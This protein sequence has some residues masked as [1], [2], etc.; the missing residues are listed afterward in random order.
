MRWFFVPVGARYINRQ[1]LGI[2]FAALAILL[3]LRWAT[4]L[5]SFWKK[6]PPA[7]SRQIAYSILSYCACRN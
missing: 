3:S 7:T 2:F 1:V 5:S 6:R 4:G